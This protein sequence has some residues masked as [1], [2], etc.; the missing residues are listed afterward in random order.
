[1]LKYTLDFK[2]GHAYK[3]FKYKKCIN[4]LSG[5]TRSNN[6]STVA[7]E[8]FECVWPFCGVGA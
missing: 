3:R 5:Q 6:S 7:E 1:M 8:L 4:P 2:C